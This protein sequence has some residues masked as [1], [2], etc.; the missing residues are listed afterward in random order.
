VLC[1]F[2]FSSPEPR[3]SRKKHGHAFRQSEITSLKALSPWINWPYMPNKPEVLALSSYSI[4]LMIRVSLLASI[5]SFEN[6]SHETNHSR[7]E[8]SVINL[9]ISLSRSLTS[10]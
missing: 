7:A 4:V 10:S 5:N 9:T 3:R 1:S 6:G 8:A 2:S